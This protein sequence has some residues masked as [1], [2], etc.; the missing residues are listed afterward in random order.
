MTI[1]N[2]SHNGWS[3]YATWRINL[4][5]F[6]DCDWAEVNSSTDPA[7]LAEQLKESLEM[8]IDESIGWS[9]SG[10]GRSRSGPLLVRGWVDAFVSDVNFYEIANHIIK[11]KIDEE[12]SNV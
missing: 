2:S 8:Y 11:E 4:E 6:D 9:P 5:I 7:D 12:I 10:M 3:N 1:R